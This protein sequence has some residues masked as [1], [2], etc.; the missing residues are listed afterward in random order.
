MSFTR[1][2]WDEFIEWQESVVA[3]RL[4]TSVFLIPCSILDIHYGHCEADR[5]TC[6]ELV[7]PKQSIHDYQRLTKRFSL[8][9]K[10]RLKKVYNN[11]DNLKD[12]TEVSPPFTIGYRLIVY[13]S[14]LSNL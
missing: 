7:E 14:T 12:R 2:V 10:Y 3:S 1:S 13:R 11:T 5:P 6:S 8:V 4:F 9:P